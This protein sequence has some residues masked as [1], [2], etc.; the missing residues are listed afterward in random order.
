LTLTAAL[1][2]AT[3]VAIGFVSGSTAARS[4]TRQA[5]KL[6][7]GV[8]CQDTSGGS[9][10][11]TRGG[12]AM[13]AVDSFT[14]DMLETIGPDG[15]LKP[16]L[17]LSVSQPNPFVYIY[18][19]RHG[20]KFWD[21][22][23]LTADDVA[24]AI[25][26]ARAPN[27]DDTAAWYPSVR[28]V[29]ATDRYTVQMTMKRPDASARYTLA[30][31]N[32]A[33][34]IF[35]R[36]FQQADA[37]AFGTPSRLLMGSGPYEIQSYDPLSG[38]ELTANPHY[39][40]GTPPARQVS[41]K[42]FSSEQSMAL[43]FRAGQ[44]DIAFPDDPQGFSAT[45]NTKVANA[46]GCLP[47]FLTFKT[48]V[49]PFSDVHVRRAIA[50]ALDRTAI[51]K[52]VGPQA[53]PSSTVIAAA[54]LASLAPPSQVSALI[55][56]LPNGTFDLAKA[57]QE[58]AQS[59][60]PNGFSMDLYSPDFV[61]WGSVASQVVAAQLAK[62]NIKVTVRSGSIGA[63]VSNALETNGA[64]N[65]QPFITEFYCQYPDPALNA[66]FFAYSNGG[67]PPINYDP[68]NYVNATADALINTADKLQSPAKR[69][70]AYS[71][72]LRIYASEV[73]V[74]GLFTLG[75]S[76]AISSRFTF[77]TFSGYTSK[78]SPFVMRLKAR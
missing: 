51:A 6:V 73:P 12:C 67:K 41:I 57:K 4:L 36:K 59:K 64:K 38:A 27:P 16:S 15:H 62:I 39:W 25:N 44:V 53:T 26:Y 5:P 63:W 40:G 66:R 24:N 10:D 7:F 76:L 55:R 9:L 8:L 35:E 18:H 50:D 42:F 11:P 45:A 23:E 71:K 74:V 68:P 46:S 65:P 37:K 49:A 20:V 61:A 29:K 14:L 43:A 1:A 69:F 75:P 22:T 28:S 60:V 13:S 32:G 54:S 30:V 78:D 21:G 72:V 34:R 47:G 3:A 58:L 33:A 77:P 48:N 31:G 52:A 2:A 17:A 19:L 70:A 56:S